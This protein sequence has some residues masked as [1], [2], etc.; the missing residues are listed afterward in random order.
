MPA[1]AIVRPSDLFSAAEWKTLSLR[2]LWRGPWLVLHCWLSIMAAMVIFT[3]YPNPVTWVVAVMIVGTRQLG[4]A[5]LMHDSAHRLLAPSSS[6]NDLLGDWICAVPVGADLASY[7]KYHFAHH[8]YT[9]QPE[10]P[11]L[12]LS[13]AFPTTRASLKRKIIRDL[14][15]QTF[16]KQRGAAVV[17][18]LNGSHI[19][20]SDADFGGASRRAMIRFLV[21]NI[22]FAFLCAAAGGLIAFLAVWLFAMATWFPLVT[23]IRN[24]AEHACV[25]DNDDPMRYARTVEAGAL[26][27]ALIAPYFVNFHAEHHMFAQLPCYRLAQ[28]H[29]LL[30]QKGYGPRI[31][32][33]RSYADVL[34]LVTA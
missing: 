19:R 24:I 33:R 4:L 17:A 12:P 23:R 2:S 29:R 5:I 25:P 16:L 15:G 34:R 20:T 21:F 8:R 6:V 11:D 22:A 10:D 28:S 18:A 13:A 7:R 3:L 31:E 9:Q 1:A 26:E 27:R 30:K 14:T 32:T